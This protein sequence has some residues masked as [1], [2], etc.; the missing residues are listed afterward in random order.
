[1]SETVS[2]SQ[3][4]KDL[5]E[6][7]DMFDYKNNGLVNP[8]ELKEIMDAMSMRDKNPFLY[9]LI[10]DLCQNKKIKQK[11]GISATDFISIID[12]EL[13]NT[14]SI[15]GLEKIFTVFYNPNSNKVS[16]PSF[17]EV[18]KEIGDEEKESQI[19]NLIEKSQLND[20]EIN[21][22]EFKDIMKN[23][24]Q[25][26][27]N[28][29]NMVYVKKSSSLRESYNKL[30]NNN[31]YDNEF[32]DVK[33]VDD[34]IDKFDN[35]IS[36]DNNININDNNK[37]YY[38]NT[39]ENMNNNNSN[40]NMSNNNNFLSSN[41]SI[42]SNL[43]NLNNLN[44]SSINNNN[45]NNF[46]LTN[47]YNKED[48][49]QNI[50]NKVIEQKIVYTRTNQ[51]KGSPIISTNPMTLYDN[52]ND[53]NDEPKKNINKKKFYRHSRENTKEKEKEKIPSESN[54][55]SINRNTIEAKIEVNIS[56]TK[57]TGKLISD[58]NKDDVTTTA[59][60]KQRNVRNKPVVLQENVIEK[61][62]ET[63]EENNSINN[64]SNTK[65]YH[66]R[67][68]ENK[69]SSGPKNGNDMKIEVKKEITVIR[70]NNKG[71]ENNF[72]FKKAATSPF[73]KYKKK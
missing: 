13:N 18:A 32:N 72:G 3:I 50:E 37:N 38:I 47:P 28:D 60:N 46:N 49:Q 24:K 44:N 58:D 11:G 14:S 1:M 12:D 67:Y 35:Y 65:R 30:S 34:D 41:I 54:T 63:K 10:D 31:N 70:G 69:I 8:N 20:K 7:F 9:N 23:T 55:D 48:S 27:N 52:E 45:N 33:D 59:S 15:D 66:R 51:R 68:R 2:K 42:E 22:N 40:N 36:K 62:T 64:D 6:G 57:T 53:I 5:K 26:T 39:F 16:L 29:N 61:K 21:F 43:K 73:L 4:T 56:N 71:D 17:I 19:K 25:S